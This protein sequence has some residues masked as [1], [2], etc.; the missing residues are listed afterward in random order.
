LDFTHFSIAT[1]KRSLG[2]STV[3]R[4]AYQSGHR[5]VDER[6]GQ[7]HDYRYRR[8]NGD[9]ILSAL[10]HPDGRI[11][12]EP[13]PTQLG[14]LWNEV[15]KAE[16]RKDSQVGRTGIVA[17]PHRL[18]RDG[19]QQVVLRF[20]LTLA[21]RYN[22]PIQFDLHAPSRHKAADARNIHGHWQMP[23]RSLDEHGSFHRGGKILQLSNRNQ[24]REEVKAIRGLWVDAVNEELEREGIV[25]EDGSPVRLDA[26]SYSDCG[27]DR[28]PE[29][30]VGVAA[31]ALE[32]QG[33]R[34]SHGDQ[35]R[36]IRADNLIL[37]R[38]DQ[39]LG[40]L[41]EERK[42]L[43]AVSE[44]S[45]PADSQNRGEESPREGP[46]RDS[47]S[48]HPAPKVPDLTGLVSDI[49]QYRELVEMEKAERELLNRITETEQESQI[50]FD[51][52]LRAALNEFGIAM[53]QVFNDMHAAERAWREYR[54]QH[55]S[56]GAVVALRQSPEL[57]G[58]L[59]VGKASRLGWWQDDRAAREAAPDAA[60]AGAQLAQ[61]LERIESSRIRAEERRDQL[62]AEL[63]PRREWLQVM[64][65]KKALR[66]RI[67]EQW[68]ALPMSATDMLQDTYPDVARLVEEKQQAMEPGLT[69][70][71]DR[72]R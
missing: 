57:F 8:T 19:Q 54:S 55:G 2:Q 56:A 23:T 33:I 29:V 36:A 46:G 12:K 5:L 63:R 25:R 64:E 15:E 26:R 69:S 65:R 41:E 61:E 4:A 27:I 40:H 43:A 52:P 70:G 22:T 62:R 16:R 42:L 3:A 21:Q 1:V 59:R 49:V 67:T 38:L 9:V 7:A 13:S 66:L 71:L 68:L 32:R 30:H 35:N 18:S 20:S 10:V 34:T 24:A 47:V 17:F 44:P 28:I 31:T 72:T 39:R 53:G 14:S 51:E 58:S 11:W 48:H 50:A 45:Q 6:T 60:E 37:A